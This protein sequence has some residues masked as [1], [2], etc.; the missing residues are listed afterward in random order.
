MPSTQKI[1]TPHKALTINLDT[2]TFG[3][4]AEIGAAGQEALL[5]SQLR[6]RPPLG[7]LFDYLLAS[8]FLVPMRLPVKA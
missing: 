8:N 5:A 3:S 7:H 1:D 2:S 4:F 6:S